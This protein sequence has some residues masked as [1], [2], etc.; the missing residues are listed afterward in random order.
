MT[1]SHN[2]GRF[3][4]R[5]WTILAGL[6]SVLALGIVLFLVY[7]YKSPTSVLRLYYSLTQRINIGDAGLLSDG[8]APL[9]VFSEFKPER[10]GLIKCLPC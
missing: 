7:F 6:L 3:T 4:K 9:P 8:R 2:P 5:R 1:Q 10:P